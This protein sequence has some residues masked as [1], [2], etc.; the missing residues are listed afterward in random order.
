MK[1]KIIYLSFI[2]VLVISLITLSSIY[3]SKDNKYKKEYNT[4][5]KGMAIMIKEEGAT[6][7]TKST[8]KDIPKGDYVLNRDKSYCK[9]NGKIGNYDSSLGKVSFSFS[10][11]DSCYLYFDY[12][13]ETIKLGS[14]E[15]VVNSEV[16]DF[17][18]IATTNEGLFKADDDYTAT[19]GMKSYYFRGAVD[20]NWVKYGKYT[21]DMYN[22]NNGTLSNTDTGN[23]CT[24]IASKGDDM[25]WR[26]I[27]IN[28][29]NS[30]RMIYS[31]ITPPTESTKVIKTTDTSLG[32]SP[33]NKDSNS[34]E[35]VGYMYTIKEQHGTSKS[36]DIK[37]FLDNWY[38][39]YTDLNKT[40]TKITDQIYCNDRT[41]STSDVSY[42]TTNYTTLTS[43]NSTGTQYYYGAYGRVWNSP[44]SPDYKCPTAS[45]KF[46]VNISN[47]NGALTYPVGL[48]TADEV[49]M[50]GGTNDTDN[51]SYYLYT[52]QNYWSGSPYYFYSSY[53]DEF[54]VYSSGTV[55]G[56]AVEYAD[57]ARPVISLSAEAKLTGDG[58]W[59][60]VFEV[61]KK[62]YE[63]ILAN[64]TVNETTPDFSKVTT[65]SEKGLYKADDDYT[66]TTGMK[67][68][69]FRGA[70][71]NNW[72]K[73]G[74]DSTGKDIYWRI[75]R[76]NGDGT[77]RMIY[78]GTTAPTSSTAT[79]MTGTGTQ[80]SNVAFNSISNKTEYV[81]YQY[82]EG[83]QH[84][85]GKC[86]GTNNASCTVNEN[87]VY[88][89][90]IKQAI[91]KWYAG[92]TLKDNSLISQDQIFCNDRSASSTQT[93]AWTS[94]A[95][96]LYGAYGRLINK[97]EPQ[98]TCPTD[99][100]K[101]TVNISNGNGALTYPVGLITADEVAM[102]GGKSGTGTGNSTYYL[103]TNQLYW[104]GSPY[105]FSSSYANA[106]AFYVYSSGNLSNYYVNY[107]YGARPVVSL[108]SKVKLSG[109]GTYDDV[110]T[111]VGGNS[112]E[113]TS[114][115][116]SFDTVFAKN[117]TDIFDENGLRYEG[118]DPNN[119]ICL[120]NK[121]SGACSDSSLLFRIIG[122]FDEDTSTDGTNSSG[123]KKL[124][125]VIDTNNYG[126]KNGKFW[127]SVKSNNWSTASLKT[128]LNGTYLTTLLGASNVNS[129]LSSGIANAKWHLGGASS[130]NYQTLTAEGI[131]TE[132]RNTSAIY[133][134]NPSSIYAKVGLM[135]PS[136]Y[137]YAT[138]GG[139][140]TNK[141]SCRAQ[142]LIYWDGSPYSD[143]KNNDWLFKSQS[144]FVNNA[145]WLI[146]PNASN[147][148]YASSLRSSGYVNANDGVNNLQFAMRP[149]FYLD[150]S[151]L[152]IVGTGDGTKDNAYRVG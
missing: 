110:Y 149:T 119:Y 124:L 81:G 6:D 28:G 24:K 91:D 8:S 142:A 14:T 123:T 148:N 102:A 54:Q 140:T 46:T 66:A 71:D 112:T 27:R 15:L 47:G 48:I 133:S 135:Y 134:G 93:A 50:A 109:S 55:D 113:N 69:Y 96:Y 90:T 77:I 42:S 26:I 139:T 73:F 38:A 65:A 74:K 130:S 52:N 106:Y 53:A 152:K 40:G 7:Y 151:V 144:S 97:K 105:I 33:F 132:E 85:Y 116:K 64:N 1:K 31:G 88:N 9:N 76:I 143:C 101:F 35:Y 56:S 84:G 32:N 137:G 10:G 92:T 138:V 146:S 103:Y 25:Y 11:T 141:S 126:G 19:T 79:V 120:D 70:V 111:V 80:I 78:T 44:V 17:N 34:A 57:G 16:P 131:Y 99:S 63:T 21:K 122:L 62:G 108:S 67:S 23:S 114:S 4:I 72:V 98:L 87:T 60:N 30:I 61:E 12:K 51:S 100:D 107:T 118:A 20:N 82:I 89:S 2:I 68:Y 36:S 18:Q 147:S 49:A 59:N 121:T 127:N 86:D 95:T 129:K 29:D 3:K 37:T 94:T 150:S 39:N 43:W 83:Q 5:P 41:A 125:K 128:E 136:D 117:N 104:L 22:C 45:D 115:G 58:T 13:K 145:E 75:I